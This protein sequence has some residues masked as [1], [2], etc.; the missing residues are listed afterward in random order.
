MSQGV[1]CVGKN[2][3][4]DRKCSSDYI[5]ILTDLWYCGRINVYGQTGNPP[6]IMNEVIT[7]NND[8]I[9]NPRPEMLEAPMKIFVDQAGYRPGDE[10]VAVLTFPASYFAVVDQ[11]GMQVLS[12]SVVS[13]GHDEAFGDDTWR[14]DFSGL[15]TPGEYRVVSGS[16]SSEPFKIRDDVYIDCFDKCMKAFYFQRCGCEL[17]PQ[18]AGQ[19]IHGK[20][21]CGRALLWEN[22]SVSLEVSGG[23]HDA[24]D[25]GR[26]TTAAATALAHLI[27]G[28]KLYPKAFRRQDLNIPGKPSDMPDVLI[29]CR[30][31]L[32]WLLKMQRFDGAVWHKATT[33]Q[34][35]DFVMPEDDH[36]QMYVLPVSSSA[37]ADFAAVTALA[38]TVYRK[39]DGVFADWL[40]KCSLAAYDWLE[41][42]PQ[43]IG[44]SN[45]EGC[46]TGVYG[47][48]S[49]VDN[50]FWAAA[51]L[52]SVT[53]EERYYTKL[54]ALIQADFPRTALGFAS[55][56][57]F[58]AVSLLLSGR[59]GGSI[60]NMLH[61][62]FISRAEALA[63][64]CDRSGWGVSLTPEDFHW[65]SNMQVLTNGMIFLIADWLEGNSV[66]GRPRF[67]KYAK[68][69][70]D[71]LLG[72]NA[73]GY[74][75]VTGVGSFC[76]NY[77][78]HR[79]AFAD[80]IEECFPGL[81]SGG[82]D[83]HRDDKFAEELIPEGT[84]PMKC[85][86]DN[87]ECYSLNEVT[88]Y[89]NSPAVFL[90]AGLSE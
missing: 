19:W 37:T 7:M 39:Y 2:V 4:T 25:Y 83:S 23:W 72:V 61:K 11:S 70:L 36:G 48:H 43:F 9:E 8:E 60:L 56:G 57:G 3:N 75:F 16:E 50:R 74:S 63:A 62:D 86:S 64:V 81:V 45:P 13:A 10:K 46:G 69:Q 12:G 49:D 77:P 84:P 5:F 22:H 76:V 54:L 71:Y 44:F 41:R 26:Y 90:L 80:K 40:M 66:I 33:A 87:M 38:S 85:Y 68:M 42:N 17:L 30:Y 28:W 82:P 89:W 24:G 79:Q 15:K 31:E 51:E 73:T 34:H 35:A 58:G 67:R 78:H 27:Y 21:H 47:E 18:Y 32:E 29:E 14:A 6:M 59:A 52:F 53:G 1:F 65:G 20:C 55:V 88:I